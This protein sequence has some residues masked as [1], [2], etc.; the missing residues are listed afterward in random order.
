M[1][2]QRL[3]TALTNSFAGAI[4]LGWLFGQGIFHFAYIFSAPIAGW[5]T[6]REYYHGM[7]D[8]VAFST[9]RFSFREMLAEL[10]RSLS[11]L[12]VAYIL[13]RWLYYEPSPETPEP[14][15]EQSA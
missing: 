6:R 5:L 7:A 3:K 15:P 1:M 10:V 12:L 13:L 2:L 14:H 4:A 9:L 8:R 11:L